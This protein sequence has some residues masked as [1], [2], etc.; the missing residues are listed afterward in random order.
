MGDDDVSDEQ[1]I[2]NLRKR[3]RDAE[4]EAVEGWKHG[5]SC[6]RLATRVIWHFW[7]ANITSTMLG[8]ILGAAA[9]AAY[10]NGYF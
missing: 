7:W 3:T 1:E 4:R 9:V 8:A 2:A 6:N 10:I 5:I